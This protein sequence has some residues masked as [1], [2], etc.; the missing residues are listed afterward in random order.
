MMDINVAKRS[1]RTSNTLI[2][3][4]YLSILAPIHCTIPTATYAIMPN[5]LK[6]RRVQVEPAPLIAGN[7]PGRLA[8]NFV[9]ALENRLNQRRTIRRVAGLAV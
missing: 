7:P 3:E 2:L 8:Y 5:C 6:K 1:E 4:S 9:S